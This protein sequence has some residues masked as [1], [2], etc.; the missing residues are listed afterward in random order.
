MLRNVPPR[1]SGPLPAGHRATSRN[2]VHHH[3]SVS[4]HRKQ[5]TRREARKAAIRRFACS[6]CGEL[7]PEADL[8]GHDRALLFCSQCVNALDGLD[9]A[10][11]DALSVFQGSMEC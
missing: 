5:P 11:V 1:K 6:F 10:P 2:T 9:G 7:K 3:C 8:V 4:H